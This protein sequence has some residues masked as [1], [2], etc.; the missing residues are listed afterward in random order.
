MI[1]QS[2]SGGRPGTGNK[3]ENRF[4]YSGPPET[5]A[6]LPGHQNCIG[7]GFE[8]YGV[9]GCQASCNPTAGDGN[10]KIPG[11]NHHPDPLAATPRDRERLKAPV[12]SDLYRAAFNDE[13]TIEV[14]ERIVGSRS[15]GMER[16]LIDRTAM[17]LAVLERT[18]SPAFH[19]G[20]N[21]VLEHES[22]D[23]SGKPSRVINFVKA[24]MKSYDAAPSNGAP[25]KRRRDPNNMT[26]QD[27]RELAAE[28]RARGQ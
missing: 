18:N 2:G 26:A 27:L 25:P 6:N 4:G 9:A 16:S 11:R 3:L 5:L 28:Q 14:L 8:N 7:G 15:T 12:I 24:C 13:I 10:R 22:F 19:Y 20:C 17:T 21:A 23:W 1:R